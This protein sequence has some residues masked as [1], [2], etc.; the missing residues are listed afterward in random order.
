MTNILAAA[1]PYR[2]RILYFFAGFACVAIGLAVWHAV[3]ASA[4]RIPSDARVVTVTPVF[5]SDPDT[6]REKLDHA[7]TIT[8]PAKV[9]SIV[10]VINGLDP[11][12]PGIMSCPVDNGAAMQLTFRTS[13][14]GQ[15]VASVTAGYSGCHIV[16]VSSAT[17]LPPLDENTSSGQPMQQQVLA[18]AGVGWPY[19]PGTPPRSAG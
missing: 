4:G 18:I 3:Q 6:S 8:D 19:T 13:P 7:F 12:Q 15:V 9:T 1:R 11:I 2:R 16:T 5:G 10:A 17:S 14:G